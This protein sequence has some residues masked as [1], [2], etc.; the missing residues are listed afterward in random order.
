MSSTGSSLS[1]QRATRDGLGVLALTTFDL[2]NVASG[3]P[4]IVR[5]LDGT[6]MLLRLA[7]ADEVIEMQRSALR[8][9]P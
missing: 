6:E 9:S 5:M 7:T 3:H 4:M 8:C 1:E 2:I